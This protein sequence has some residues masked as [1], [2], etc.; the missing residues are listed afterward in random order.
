MWV[1]W[2]HEYADGSA[3]GGCFWQGR[4]GLDFRPGYLL[5]GGTTTAHG[6]INATLAVNGDG[7]PTTLRVET[8]GQSFDFVLESACGPLHFVGR[9][10]S[11]SA[12]KAPARSWCWIEYP[13]GMLTP[14]ILD[15][16][17]EKFQLVWDR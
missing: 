11:S 9:L 2:I 16:T 7:K 5:D 17:T 14:E 8:G 6:D 12:G 15:L 13:N 4:D 10:A 3:G 1:S